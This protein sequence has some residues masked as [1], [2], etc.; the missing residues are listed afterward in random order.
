MR[1]ALVERGTVLSVW[2]AT[3][4]V[5]LMLIVGLGVDLAGQSAAEQEARSSARQAARAAGQA[6][7][8]DGATGP[9]ISTEPARRLA[10]EYLSAAG[11]RGS[12]SIEAG[13]TVRVR[14]EATY[15]TVFLSL[16][17]VRDLPVRA[18]ESASILLTRGG[19]PR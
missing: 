11:Y 18:D 2:T 9:I 4:V 19:A 8:G 14:V 12:V 5:A 3:S 7:V 17:G 6:V 1:R 10:A 16:I 13:R 15:P